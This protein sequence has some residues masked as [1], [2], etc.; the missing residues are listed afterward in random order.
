LTEL[1]AFTQAVKELSNLTIGVEIPVPHGCHHRV[2]KPS[3]VK[4]HK[5]YRICLAYKYLDKNKT[6][7]TDLKYLEY[8]LEYII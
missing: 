1:G 2:E 5:Q 8:L 3:W 6:T 4:Q 7:A